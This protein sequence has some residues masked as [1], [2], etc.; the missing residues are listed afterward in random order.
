MK[1]DEKEITERLGHSIGPWFADDHQSDHDG[2]SIY[3]EAGVP[4]ALVYRLNA[5]NRDLIVAAPDLLAGCEEAA[6]SI[7]AYHNDNGGFNGV[8]SQLADAIK[9]AK[10]PGGEPALHPWTDARYDNLVKAAP[11]LLEV[12]ERFLE[13]I[14]DPIE[15]NV[16]DVEYL[17]RMAVDKAKEPA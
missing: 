11:A 9:K 8:L 7:A 5:A 10:N 16:N 6:A 17:A 15:Y 12:T 13:Y 14:M 3:N 2:I 1:K 4:I